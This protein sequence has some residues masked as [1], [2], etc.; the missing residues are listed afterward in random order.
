MKKKDMFSAS[1]VNI[2]LYI[3]IGSVV[4]FMLYFAVLQYMIYAGIARNKLTFQIVSN[5]VQ[6]FSDGEHPV[7]TLRATTRQESKITIVLAHYNMNFSSEGYVKD[8]SRF[9]VLPKGAQ[10]K[11]FEVLAVAED[12]LENRMEKRLKFR[13]KG[14]SVRFSVG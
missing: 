1:R 11:E 8:Y 12:R 2:L 9:L 4:L 7:L 6:E 3:V 13:A 10:G 14:E 5:E